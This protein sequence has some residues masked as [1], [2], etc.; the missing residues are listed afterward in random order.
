MEEEVKRQ[1]MEEEL[2]IG[3][4]IR[5]ACCPV[6]APMFLS[7]LAAGYCAAHEVGGDLYDFIAQPDNPAQIHLIIGDVTARVPAALY[8]AVSR[9][10]LHTHALEGQA[11]A[12]RPASMTSSARTPLRCSC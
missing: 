5:S 9:T 10:L 3:R 2:V 11:W 7:R 8:M 4:R 1:R 6:V 12:R